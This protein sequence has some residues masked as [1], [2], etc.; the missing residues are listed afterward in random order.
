MSR[1]LKI[2]LILFSLSLLA[3]C[4]S[5]TDGEPTRRGEQT[6]VPALTELTE[7]SAAQWLRSGQ[8]L[9]SE[10]QRWWG[11]PSSQGRSG[12]VLWD[13]YTWVGQSGKGDGSTRML[14]LTLNYNLQGIL[15]DYDLRIHEFPAYARP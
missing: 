13:N 8:T 14:S 6:R 4:A 11:T 5:T 12:D 3:A 15:Q 7:E 10:I 9:N 2:T 1:Y